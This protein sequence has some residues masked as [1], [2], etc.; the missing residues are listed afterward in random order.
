MFETEK[1]MPKRR[2]KIRR[3]RNK[4]SIID[5]IFCA[6]AIVLLIGAV[7]YFIH[8]RKQEVMTKSE[9]KNKNK[10]SNTNSENNVIIKDKAR[11]DDGGGNKK[12]KENPIKPKAQVTNSSGE[13]Q[14]EQ[15]E[16][17]DGEDD[18]KN[19]QEPTISPGSDS[20][21][22]NFSGQIEV[23]EG[24]NPV[25]D[26]FGN[27]DGNKDDKSGDNST[28][29][30]AENV[31]NPKKETIINIEKE[32]EMLEY[33]EL[34]PL[35]LVI[36]NDNVKVFEKAMEGVNLN[37][38]IS[39]NGFTAL[40]YAASLLRVDIMRFIIEKKLLSVKEPIKDGQYDGNT[41]LHLAC[42][43]AEVYPDLAVEAVQLLLN[44]GAD[45]DALDKNGFSPIL[46][47]IQSGNLKL[48]EYLLS[49]YPKMVNA[50]FI[51]D[52]ST[53]LHYAMGPCHRPMLKLLIEK[54]PEMMHAFNEFNREPI[55]EAAVMGCVDGLRELILTR[56]VSKQSPSPLKK[57]NK[58]QEEYNDD[59]LFGAAPL[60]FA[61][62]AGM[63]NTIEFLF[64]IQSKFDAR[65]EDGKG[66]KY[67]SKECKKK[68]VEDYFD[69]RLIWE[70][71]QYD[72]N[73]DNESWLRNVEDQYSPEGLEKFYNN[74]R[75]TA[76][77]NT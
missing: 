72:D 39:S 58:C 16:H 5:I 18:D 56:R 34:P 38:E 22:N 31:N 50:R 7:Y 71:D 63:L 47:A 33:G 21:G 4:F 19:T 67:Y 45:I 27:D 32:K 51:Y 52:G 42:L 10:K 64:L 29:I 12:E 59:C 35:L 15:E 62:K 74:M 41:A 46:C 76:L 36:K 55:H 9:Q 6:C 66:A 49:T 30:N 17:E 65:D 1:K 61:A 68:E 14:A 23:E 77:H 53:L 26:S 13:E 70:N 54:D 44:D 28:N 60:H 37:N 48:V 40:H 3:K 73:Q 24:S 43:A 8:D 20:N 25:D 2:E 57:E 69:E 75:R 11:K